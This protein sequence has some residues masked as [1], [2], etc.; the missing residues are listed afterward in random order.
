MSH[1]AL[2]TE[3][4]EPSELLSESVPPSDAVLR[5]W[6]AQ[7]LASLFSP[8]SMRVFLS[9]R[10][11]RQRL[12]PPGADTELQLNSPVAAT[13][14]ACDGTQ[15]AE[16]ALVLPFTSTF[17][18]ADSTPTYTAVLPATSLGICMQLAFTF[19]IVVALR[20]FLARRCR[21]RRNRRLLCVSCSRQS[22]QQASC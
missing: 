2:Y 21:A 3:A 18:A 4:I 16:A 19:C 11:L 8:S 12:Q 9:G 1:L 15:E 22:S 10:I 5:G 17:M 13:C 7:P 20:A 14:P 6:A